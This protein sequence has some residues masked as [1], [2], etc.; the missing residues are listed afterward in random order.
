LNRALIQNSSVGLNYFIQLLNKLASNNYYN[1][2]PNVKDELLLTTSIRF[3]Y[4]SYIE[5]Y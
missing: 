1:Y 2:S 3:V 4:L 5:L